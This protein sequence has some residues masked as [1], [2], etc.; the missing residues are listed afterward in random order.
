MRSEPDGYTLFL[1][2]ALLSG[3][4]RC[5]ANCPTIRAGFPDAVAGH[6]LPVVMAVHPS[7]PAKTVAELVAYAGE[8]PGKINFGSAGTGGTIHLAGEMF[9]QIAGVRHG[10]RALQGRGPGADRPDIGQYPGDVDT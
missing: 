1:T 9:K 10:A 2:A 5:S 6:E 3:S 4:T 7:V 8:N